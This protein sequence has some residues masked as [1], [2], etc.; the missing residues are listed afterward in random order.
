M[1]KVREKFLDLV[2]YEI[3][4]RSFSDSNGD[5]IGDI[6]GIVEKLDHLA[7]L[8]VNAIWLCPCFESPNEDN[9]YDISDYKKIGR[10]FGALSDMETLIERVHARG[11][12]LFLDL[13]AN[14]TSQEHPWFVN[15]RKSKKNPYRN[16]YY[17]SKK[18]F[19]K[20]KSLVGGSAWEYDG[21]SGEYYLHSFSKAQPDLNWGNP[22]VR[23]EIREVV[24]FWTAK[25]VDG[26]RCDM[27]DFIGKDFENGKMFG[28]ERMHEYIREL[29]DG[30]NEGLFTVGE[31]QADEKSIAQLCAEDRKELS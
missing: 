30:V 20:W 12:K 10:E 16:Y 26:F 23:A 14:H 25:G 29:F 17:W 27:L 21:E 9:G 2:V 15:A 28:D 24:E 4:I 6:R 7:E 5:G 13:V 31:C 18:P 11:M 8:G 3:Y 1:N 22:R 19:P